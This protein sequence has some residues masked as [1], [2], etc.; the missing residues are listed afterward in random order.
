MMFSRSVRAIGIVGVALAAACGSESSTEPSVPN[1]I[2]GV[3]VAAKS[4]TSVTVTFS[5]NT[6]SNVPMIW[7]AYLM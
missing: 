4:A 7:H 2:V 5:S 1:P 6:L 3:A